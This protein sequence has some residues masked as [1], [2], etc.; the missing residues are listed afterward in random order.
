MVVEVRRRERERSGSDCC[1]FGGFDGR[2]V[3]V[4]TRRIQCEIL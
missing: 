2:G 4:T 3:L 1:T